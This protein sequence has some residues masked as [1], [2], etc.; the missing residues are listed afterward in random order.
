MTVATLFLILEWVLPLLKVGLAA[1]IK[2]DLPAEII[3]AAESAIV[4][5][6]KILAVQEPTRAQVLALDIDP[7]A[8]GQPPTP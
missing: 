3:D 1:F 6:E 2:S 8:W 4:A 5:I 7:A